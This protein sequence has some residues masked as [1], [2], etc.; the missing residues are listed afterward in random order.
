MCIICDGHS[1]TPV[2]FYYLETASQPL[3]SILASRRIMYLHHILSRNSEELIKRV[4]N[5]QKDNIT[6]GDFLELVKGDLANIGE[7]F[8][9]ESIMLQ[10]KPQYKNHIKKKIRAKVFEDLK[11]MQ[12]G[13]SKIRGIKYDHFKI[14]SYVTSPTFSNEMVSLLFNM[15]CSM[16]RGIKCN[17]PSMFRGDMK[18]KL[19]CDVPEALDSQ[20]HL[21]S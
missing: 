12:M 19:K 1:K 17:F 20:Q 11:A 13:H 5:A 8:D 4:F 14:Q 16:T 3:K 21:K 9:E 10:T 2:E 7:A 18:C 15:R 6:P